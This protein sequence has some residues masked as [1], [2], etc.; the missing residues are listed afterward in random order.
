MKTSPISYFN[1]DE[2]SAEA[3]HQAIHQYESQL[4]RERIISDKI[5]SDGR[6][7]TTVRNISIDLGL[8]SE[9]W[10]R[11]IHSRWHSS[12]CGIDPW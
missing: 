12:A 8:L 6:N 11:F 7:L 9:P 4:T 5:R 1:N 3:I 10:F 2:L